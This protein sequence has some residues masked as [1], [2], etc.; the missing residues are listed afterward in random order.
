MKEVNIRKMSMGTQGGFTIIELIV[1]ILLLGILT[2]TALPRF[3]DVTDEA[4]QAV[5]DAVEGGLITGNAL[6]RAGY[7]AEGADDSSAVSS[8]GAGTMFPDSR[9]SSGYPVGTDNL[10]DD[11]NDCLA[12][13]NAVLQTGAPVIASAAYDAAVATQETNI[14]SAA[15]A[16]T[17]F[18]VTTNAPVGAPLKPTQCIFYYVAQTSS[19]TSTATAGPIQTLTYDI[20]DG[21]VT[22]GTYTFN[23]D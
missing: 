17:D 15:G 14:E 18:V 10:L 1:V 12:V 3:L 23:Q 22:E 21:S 19:G 7:I 6:F 20:T 2:A 8:F 9:S 16:N 5:V 4:H 11:H 13:Y